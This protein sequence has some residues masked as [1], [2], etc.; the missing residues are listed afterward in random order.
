[1]HQTQSLVLDLGLVS[2]R[3]LLVVFEVDE[4]LEGTQVLV[5]VA[6]DLGLCS[7]KV[8]LVFIIELSQ[9]KVSF[10]L[11]NGLLH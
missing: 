4:L 1:M 2:L 5:Q 9:A 10:N 11:V 3:H 6:F 7:R 8:Q